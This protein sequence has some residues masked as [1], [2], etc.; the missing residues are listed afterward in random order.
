MVTGGH[1]RGLI[2]VI[3]HCE[4]HKGNFDV[5]HVVD[6]A[7][8]QFAAWMGMCSPLDRELSPGLHFPEARVSSFLLWARPRSGL[9]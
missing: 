6:A 3:K 1:N 4:K 8:H 9:L 2:G 5:I 7:G